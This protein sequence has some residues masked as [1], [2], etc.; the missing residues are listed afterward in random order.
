MLSVMLVAVICLACTQIVLRTVFESGFVWLDPLL[1]YLV[2]WCGLLGAVTATAKGKHIALDLVG[3]RFPDRVAP[4]LSLVTHLFS[5]CASAGL[6]L[7]GWLFLRNEFEYG[8]TGPLTLPLWLWNTIF[9]FAFGLITVKYFL[10]I[11]L[12]LKAISHLFTQRGGDR[13]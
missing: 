8:G 13:S 6:T 9:P 5:C 2:L 1:R 10:L 4:F 11:I 3:S 7:A 12:Q